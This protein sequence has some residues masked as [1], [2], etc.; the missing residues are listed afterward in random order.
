MLEFN[1]EIN[2]KNNY[3]EAAKSFVGFL[4]NVANNYNVRI[5]YKILDNVRAIGYTKKHKTIKFKKIYLKIK[6]VPNAKVDAFYQVVPGAKVDAFFQELFL[7]K[8]LYYYS[9]T[10]HPRHDIINEVILPIVEILIE[11]FFQRPHLRSLKRHILGKIIDP[12]M[13]GDFFDSTAHNYEILF[14]KWDSCYISNYDF[15][16]DLDDL[17]TKFLLE[18]LN[19]PKGQKSPKFNLLVSKALKE[20]IIQNDDDG[21]SRI[22]YPKT[23]EIFNEVHHLRTM[24]LHRL[25][26]T[27]KREDVSELAMR[28]Y[29]YFQYYDEFEESQKQKTI[30][31]DGK[32]YRR[33]KYG[34]EKWLD[35]NG[36]PYLDEKGVP[37]NAYEMAK[38]KPCHDCFAVVGQYHC[39]GCDA[40]ECPVCKKQ[41][42]GCGCPDDD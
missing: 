14:R 22:H 19:H 17:L 30:K 20:N 42:M 9:Y 32:Y 31:H 29:G 1:D 38:E 5:N 26:R 34:Y 15:I 27:L 3:H 7:N 36:K 6:L 8:A 21:F 24:G 13:P 25:E 18:K 23:T 12:F 41:A 11:P 28:I 4:Q 16:K 10:V 40:E 37:Y 33:I 35:E 2:I 39:S